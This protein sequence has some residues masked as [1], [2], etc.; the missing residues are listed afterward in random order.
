[1]ALK[2]MHFKRD[3]R[4]TGTVDRVDVGIREVLDPPIADDLGD[5]DD[6]AVPFVICDVDV[7]SRYLRKDGTVVNLN[8]SSEALGIVVVPHP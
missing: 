8:G 4:D 7:Y 6:R 3:A 2:H 5:I 1:M